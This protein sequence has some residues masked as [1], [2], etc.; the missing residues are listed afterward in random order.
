MVVGCEPYAPAAFTPQEILMVLISVRGIVDPGAVVRSEG[1]NVNE[2]P[3]ITAG[4]ERTTYRPT[5][6]K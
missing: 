5:S 2:K 3:M 6:F 1:F 4:I